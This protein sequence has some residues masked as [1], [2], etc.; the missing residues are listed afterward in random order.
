MISC[1]HMAAGVRN[2]LGDGSAF[3]VR[4]RYVEEPQPLG[5]G[6]ALKYAESLLDDRFFM[7]NGDVL[8]DIDLSAQLAQHESHRRAGD[9]RADAGRGPLRTTG[10]CAR[11]A[12]AA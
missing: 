8:T 2:V 12:T 4:L 6:G 11:T 1:G 7:L 3:G 5:T 10:S 9:A